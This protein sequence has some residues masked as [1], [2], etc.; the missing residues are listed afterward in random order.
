MRRLPR[1][2]VDVPFV[3]FGSGISCAGKIVNMSLSG[4]RLDLPNHSPKVKSLVN[5]RFRPTD[6]APEFEVLARVV[7]HASRGVGVEFLDLD[8]HAKAR[9]WDHLLYLL[10]KNL[11]ACP[12]CG[13]PLTDKDGRRCPHCRHSLAFTH[14]E[15]LS[16]VLEDEQ[17]SDEEMI[18]TCQSMREVFH[19]IR[20][21]AASDVSVLIT[22][23]SGTGK[24]MV[25]RAIHERS[26][27]GKGP[28]VPI[29]CGAIPSELL[30]SEL[31]GHEKG[32]FTGAFRT[33]IGTVERARGG[34]LFLDEVGELPPAMQVKLLRFLQEFSFTRVGGRQPIQVD[35]RIISATNADLQEMTLAGRFREDL[36]YRL[37]VINLHMPPLRHRGD[38]SLIMANVFLKRYAKKVG[39]DIRGFNKQSATAILTHQWTGNVRELINRV[40]R[41]V[42]LAEGPWLTPEN[43]GLI[44]AEL[45]RINILDGR[46]L[47]EAKA[48]FE[49]KLVA[50]VLAAH[51]GNSNLASKDLKI[52][53]SMLYHLVQ[54]YNLTQY[55]ASPY[56]PD[57]KE[58]QAKGKLARAAALV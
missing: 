26:H 31:F 55:L 42:V 45:K 22:G 39:K 23:A 18:G 29:N 38:D 56:K 54:K 51:Q 13:K 19:L 9:L 43:L 17:E 49:A 34:T 36:Y 44:A 35:L 37:D 1:V 3:L 11:D 32:A 16:N 50:E 25:A 8:H 30:E 14:K 28:F 6:Q 47:K 15:Y 41:G 10:P 46:G 52:S 21:V 12:Y 33:T 4:A 57:A 58:K 20:K 27:R 48:E 24:E 40:R 7:R 53:R 5:L 2:S